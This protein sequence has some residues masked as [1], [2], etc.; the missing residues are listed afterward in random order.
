M[1]QTGN[2]VVALMAVSPDEMQLPQRQRRKPPGCGM[3]DGDSGN[4]A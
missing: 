2:A 3:N 4:G 1:S